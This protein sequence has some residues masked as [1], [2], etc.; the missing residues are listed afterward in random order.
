M[1]ES[2]TRRAL[3]GALLG[4]GVAAGSL[5][6]VRGYLER[7]APYSGS[8][9]AGATE[10][11]DGTDENPY[12]NAELRYD[13][14]GVPHLSAD[15]E[16]ALAFAVGYTQ[17]ADRLFQLDLQRRLMRGQLS[18]VVGERAFESDEFHVKM[19]FAGAAEANWE[20][21]GDTET[22]TLVEAF[23]EGVDHYVETNPLP[24]EFS[25]LSYEPAPWTPVDTML[26]EKQIAWNLTGSFRTLRLALVA[27]KLGERAVEQ[28]YPARLDHDYP[29]IRE[30]GA[31]SGGR[32]TRR[33]P[34]T[35]PRPGDVD[36]D[37]ID[38]LHRFESPPG[39]GSNS[40]VVSGNQTKSGAPIVA[41]D[42]HLSLMAPPVWYEM[43]VET[44]DLNVRGVTF[45]GVPFVVIGENDAGAWGFTNGGADVIDFYSYE[46]DDS[47]DRYRY[48]G[49]WR[50]FDTETR[51][52]EISDA[53]NREVT[54]KKS[55]HGP[56]IEREN[57][58]VGVSW[59]GHT[60]T[61]TTLAVRELNHS[62]GVA[63]T[64]AASRKFDSPTQNLVYADR[65]GNTL[66][67]LTG[68]I[69]VRTSDGE[70]VPGDRIFDGSAG[71]GEWRGFEPFATSSWKGFVPFE[72]KPHVRNPDYLATANQRITDDPEFY[73]AE[74]YSAP[75]RGK[76]IYDLLDERAAAGEPM[77]TEL[78]REIQ[79][80]TLD[81]RAVALVPDLVRAAREESVGKGLGEAARL[82]DDWDYR[83]DT[84]SRA[85]LLFAHWFEAF[86]TETFREAFEA[87]GL[88]ESYYPNDWVLANLP[89]DSRWFGDGGR[90]A[91]MVGAL[92]SAMRRN[93]VERGAT[94]GD[95]SDTGALTHPFDLDFLNYPELPKAGTD[96][97]VDDFSVESATGVSWRMICPMDGDSRAILPGGNSGDYFSDHYAD[98]LR[99]WANGEYK[100][101]SLDAS[102]ELAVE[103]EE[104]GR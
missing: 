76:R 91:V 28:L 80:D 7:F 30:G 102:G 32:E 56:L 90:E 93:A 8:A 26:M 17:A 75:Y 65:E 20:L 58:R 52:I 88:D 84:D 36:A 97:T 21:V 48:R 29:I 54:V 43:H 99:M 94:Y 34:S 18:A 53:E 46:T 19:D 61:R 42:P 70:E 96:H 50:Q 78:M 9:W 39:V 69:P 85:A 37:L 68:K 86:R 27:E 95:Y 45:P 3:V 66:Y 55:V 23:A 100:S 22:G 40:W 2:L 82:L 74:A 24:I 38:W 77:D 10:R 31:G 83:M 103:F 41:N 1:D 89:A 5:S 51:K 12:G 60:A 64:I 49:E 72:E 98:Q 16:R 87:V 92:R 47:G 79:L 13:D 15:G 44:D 71:E 35:D 63:D 11:P 25:L 6:P 81:G 59:T 104:E 33:S 73:L 67:Y 62:D 14:Y 57:R 4:G 101:M